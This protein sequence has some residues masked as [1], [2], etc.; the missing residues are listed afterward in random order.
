MKRESFII[1]SRFY[2]PIEKLSNEQMGRLFRALFRY[3]STDEPFKV[4]DDIEMAFGFFSNQMDIDNAKWLEKVEKLRA[5]AKK[6]K[7][8]QLRADATNCNQIGLDNVN[9]N[10]NE[11]VNVNDNVND[12]VIKKVA[13]APAVFVKPTVKEIREYCTERRNNVDAEAFWGFYESKGWKVGGSPM[14]NW[15]AAVIT[16]EKR[17][18]NAN[19]KRNSTTF[20]QRTMVCH[21]WSNE[22]P[23]L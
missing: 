10:V 22:R 16:W 17:K 23:T 4:D 2:K 21:D 20:E 11:N 6:S 5:N 12:N 14:K 3:C 9:V 13:H 18:D 8:K 15:K 1:Y 19:N 7:S